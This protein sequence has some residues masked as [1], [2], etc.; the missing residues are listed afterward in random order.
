MKRSLALFVVLLMAF[1]AWA[2]PAGDDFYLAERY[3]SKGL[4]GAALVAYQSA[5]DKRHPIAHHWVGVFLFEGMGAD[6]DV[7]AAIRHFTIAANQGVTGSMVYLA[8][9][10]LSANGTY[11]DCKAGEKWVKAFSSGSVPEEW[12]GRIESCENGT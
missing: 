1:P 3:R 12:A 5:A 6:K 10:F 8:N 2:T 7:S 11:R 4:F 9:I